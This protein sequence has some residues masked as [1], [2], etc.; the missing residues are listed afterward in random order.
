[1]LF[2]KCESATRNIEKVTTTDQF[3]T[4]IDDFA[5]AMQNNRLSTPTTP[6]LMSGDE[7]LDTLVYFWY[8]FITC[9]HLFYLSVILQDFVMPKPN[10]PFFDFFTNVLL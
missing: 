7:E 9:A 1:M 2:E 4:D 6:P 10:E 5:S 3:N 8:T